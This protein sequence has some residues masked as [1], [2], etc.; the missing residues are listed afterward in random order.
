M[1]GVVPDK[2]LQRRPTEIIRIF[3]GM[4]L[5]VFGAINATTISPIER[6]VHSTII[7]LPSAAL[8]VLRWMNTTGS[9]VALGIMVVAALA[10]R[11]PRFIG[12]VAL[13]A[14]L[15]IAAGRLLE[16]LVGSPHDA[17]GPIP[18]Y[19]A[20][21]SLRLAVVAA[22][23]YAASPEL[24][25]PA[26]RLITILLGLIAVSLVSVTGGYPTGIIG[27]LGLAWMMAAVAHLILGSPDGAPDGD[28][29]RSD[30]TSMGIDC[31]DLERADEQHWGETAFIGHDE[32]GPLRV[33][34]IGRDATNAQFL[35]K[36]FR[37]IWMKDSG[38]GL[39]ATREQQIEHRA[40]LLMVAERAEVPAPRV[41]DSGAVGSQ[42]DVVLVLRDSHGVCLDQI[43][44]AE[45]AATEIDRIL[46]SAWS[47][48]AH[49]H[50]AGISHGGICPSS[51][52]LGPDDSISFV[53]LASADGRP[54][55]DALVVDQVSLLTT[56]A[57]LSTPERSVAAAHRALSTDG[58]T[59]LQPLLEAAALPRSTRRGVQDLKK[60]TSTL[61]T[62][63]ADITGVT[64]EKL[65][66]L[67]RVSPANIILALATLLGFYLLIG[68]FTK[69]DF[70]TTF[71]DADWSWVVLVVLIAQL[72]LFGTAM[73]LLGAV[74]RP[75]PLRPVF[76]LQFANKF[77]GLVGGG[78]ATMA[79]TVRFFQKL[80]LSPAVAVS[81]S[82]M[83]SFAS[84]IVQFVLVGLGLL[85]GDATMKF[86]RSGGGSSGLTDKLLV[87]LAV[88][89]VIGIVL[90]AIPH[91]RGRLLSLIGPHL[92]A[93][94]S[95]FLTV[96]SEPR[97]A[98]QLFAGNFLSQ[99]C[100]ALVLWAALHAYGQSLGILQLIVINSIASII[101]GIAPVPGGMGVIEAGLIAG[102]TAAG[103]PDQAAI[104][105]TFTARTFTAYL[106]PAWGWVAMQWLH[107]NDY[108]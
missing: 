48:L 92:R 99:L 52:R 11:R 60:V 76:I 91:F 108:I 42:G 75:L 50:E 26:R 79:M 56:L 32:E 90:A 13:A 4:L 28:A 24:T 33:A 74:S 9:I 84:G 80:G 70:A 65:T 45:R 78:V 100:Y 37:F 14:A 94:R 18:G 16:A 30:L 61:S 20:F 64:P 2:G 82:L 43:E 25:R 96:V 17:N 95:N 87:L 97:K 83:T 34:V 40:Y 35:A 7:N 66:E 31:I 53:D 8:T 21:P 5:V 47:A 89:V 58:L 107:R 98:V 46:D 103:V 71:N 36:L 104:A 41:I 59:A 19:P 102:F 101:G 51:L 68:Q 54:S 105:A 106:P 6:S 3:V 12:V 63:V 72:P 27:A 29:V 38:P 85:A 86:S 67:R 77:T 44:L 62:Q 1:F 23:F 10:S 57:S 81:S 93:A 55:G 69:I 15:T 22:V 88:L 39:A 73:A 49:L